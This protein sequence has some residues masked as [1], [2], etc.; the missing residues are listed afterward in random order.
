MW[1]QFLKCEDLLFLFY[2]SLFYKIAHWTSLGFGLLKKINVQRT[3]WAFFFFPLFD[4]SETKLY[5]TPALQQSSRQKKRADLAS[6]LFLESWV[7]GD[8]KGVII[9]APKQLTHT[10]WPDCFILQEKNVSYQT[11]LSL[12]LSLCQVIWPQSVLVSYQIFQ[13][14]KQLFEWLILISRSA[15]KKS[16]ASGQRRAEK[17]GKGSDFTAGI[18]VCLHIWKLLSAVWCVGLTNMFTS[19]SC[20]S[21]VPYISLSHTCASS[22]LRVWLLPSVVCAVSEREPLSACWRCSS[23]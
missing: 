13:A 17:K 5:L 20:S 10:K 18:F 19:S 1:F 9:S 14:N 15:A 7:L 23:A 8:L 4:I 21:H 12:G 3:W 22:T 6:L 2:F 16:S 11:V